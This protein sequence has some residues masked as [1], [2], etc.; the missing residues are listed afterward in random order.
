MKSL[1]CITL[2]I[3]STLNYSQSNI[4]IGKKDKII[5]FDSTWSETLQDNHKYYRIVKD[6]LKDKE[7]YK[8]NDFYKS[9]VLE[10]EGASIS[11]DGLLKDGEF[12]YYYENGNKKA[13]TNFQMSFPHGKCYEWYEN[14]NKK[15]EGEYVKNEKTFLR[16]LKIFQFW[17]TNNALKV[18]DGNGIYEE[19]RENFF[20][21]G[22]VKDG[23]KDDLWQ[24][25]D[26][27][28]GITFIEHYSNQKLLSG[29]STDLNK[30][31]HNYSEIEKRPEPQKGIQNL[32]GYFARNLILPNIKDLDGKMYVKFVIEKDGR[33]TDIEV[34]K[35]IGYGIALEIMRIASAYKGWI[36]GEQRGIKDR[37]I[38]V[39]PINIKSPN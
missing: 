25:Y 1:F 20:A 26:K 6:Y 34:L 4:I 18:K 38:F 32:G 23:F 22:K 33:V 10:K 8:I 19:V 2:L 15:L 16:E 35:D 9:G 12:V 39:F 30:E 21:S 17:D 3:F 31:E 28:L 14:G 36:P 24:G 37:N 29:I 27:R 5:Y 13:I 11:R 7:L